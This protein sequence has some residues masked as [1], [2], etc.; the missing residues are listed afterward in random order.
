[1]CSKTIR[2]KF[3]QF[4]KQK[5][6]KHVP[7]APIVHPDDPT[8]LF[9]N[10]GMNQFK[11]CFLSPQAVSHPRVTTHQP[12]LRVSGKHNDLEEVGIDT[13]HHTLFEMLGN[14]SFGAY[15]KA[16]AI[17]WAWELL[18][19]VYGLAPD[20]LYV[21]VFGGD[22]AENLAADQEA[23]TLWQQY[24]PT[25]H[26]LY[27]TR[28]DNFW[29]M[30]DVGPCGPCTE[31]HI[32]L[33]PVGQP[34]PGRDLVNTGHPEVIEL[35]NLVFVQY[36]RQAAGQLV[37]LPQQHVDT[38]MGLERLAMVL[39]GKPSSYDTDLFQPLIEG[40]GRISA[41]VYGQDPRTDVAMR[42][43]ADHI[44]A[45]TFSIADGQAP[46][47]AQAGYVVRRI[48]R[49]AVR[50]G[51]T[52]L[53]L[54][55]PFMHQLV[56]ILVNQL[57]DIYP[58][59]QRQQAYIE[60]VVRSEEATFLQNLATGL[61]RLAH[62]TQ[63]LQTQGQQQI[64]GRTAF[65]LYDTYGFPMDLTQLIVREQGF[66]IDE[67]GFQQALAEQRTRSK[68]AA[69]VA[70]GDWHV[71]DTMR[72]ASQFIGYD[73]V[74]VPVRIVQY[75]T[76]Q[77][78]HARERYQLVLD[79][80]PFYPTGS[81][82][83]G[84][85]GKLVSQTETIDVLDTR[86]EPPFI[87]HDVS[88]LPQ[89]VQV[90]WHA[91]VDLPRRQAITRHH[92]ATHLLQ[93]VL[94][95]LLG[96][97][98]VQR[99][100]LV[101]AQLL[102][103]DFTHHTKLGSDLLYQVEQLVNQRIRANI[104]LQERR[105]VP[106]VEA[107]AAGATALFGEQYG[108]RVRVI[109]FDPD[110]S[111]ELCGGTHV[112][113]TGQLGF[114]KIISESSIAA[115]TRRIEAVAGEAAERFVRVHCQTLDALRSTLKYPKDVCKAVDDL[116]ATKVAQGKQIAFYQQEQIQAT[117]TRLRGCIQ[118]VAGYHVLIEKVV[119]PN[120][121]ALKQ[122]ALQFSRSHKPLFAVLG[123]LIERKPHLVVVCDEVI[124]NRF[125]LDAH[126][127]IQR[128]VQPIQG[129]GGGQAGLA[130]AVGEEGDGLGVVVGMAREVWK[131][132]VEGERGGG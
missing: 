13:Y 16:A 71:I 90:S 32:D 75:R 85:T 17:A 27:G 88:H 116:L 1:M 131:G 53:D 21:T 128:L 70:T 2:E 62:I 82:Q 6:H 42:V 64:D 97:H 98:V 76:I 8:L 130:T 48:L 52:Y 101:N 104:P 127:L 111:M 80:T 7:S 29:E 122:M 112:A 92:S 86:R 93:A 91:H 59:I 40:I 24:V 61:H 67:E 74:E 26:I 43:L 54:K 46:G 4:F 19:E 58:H 96:P 28:R 108:E 124:G 95:Q 50:Y 33:R 34:I 14:W 18:T 63:S 15:F 83:V 5:Q 47:P 20:R 36:N 118:V 87:I 100:S 65:E 105:D 49:R 68:Q 55:Q 69:A 126:V 117:A 73:M 114:F 23:Y 94:R 25:D 37:S 79:Q 132:C 119:L 121:K 107:K 11:A 9:T 66:Q 102:R 72:T 22:A 10:A 106:L 89:D 35:W 31:I 45:V 103:F 110:F 115:G 109:S 39:Q 44:R 51:Y 125:G 99:G 3:I 120:M 60:Q 78:A 30:G 77:E 123:A 84:D 57:G 12:C 41:Q 113:A 56:A 129:R 81:G 38:G